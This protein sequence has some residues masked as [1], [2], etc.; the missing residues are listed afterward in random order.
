M[1]LR[2]EDLTERQQLA[3]W[4]DSLSDEAFYLVGVLWGCYPEG[5]L[6]GAA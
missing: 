4:L 3:N 1:A 2:K 5:V 6:D